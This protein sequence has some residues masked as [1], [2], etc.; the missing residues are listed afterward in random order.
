MLIN[1]KKKCFYRTDGRTHGQLKTIVR[2]LKIIIIIIIIIMKSNGN[3]G[4]GFPVIISA[5]RVYQWRVT[6]GDRCLFFCI[7]N[8]NHSDEWMN[9]Q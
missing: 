1:V 4:D 7:V 6:V 3:G 8:L 2:N 9:F 5:F